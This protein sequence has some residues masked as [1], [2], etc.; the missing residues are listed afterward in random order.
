M[1]DLEPVVYSGKGYVIE[2]LENYQFQNRSQI[3]FSNKYLPGR[4]AV[5]DCA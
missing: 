3:I 1:F 5:S 4:K 2:T